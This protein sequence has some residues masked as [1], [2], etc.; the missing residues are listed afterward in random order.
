MIQNLDRDALAYKAPAPFE[1]GS[2]ETT[3]DGVVKLP[4]VAY[5]LQNLALC[6]LSLG[7]GARAL[8]PSPPGKQLSLLYLE[9]LKF[10]QSL[11]P[12]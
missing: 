5:D 11:S 1:W 10:I 6:G 12:P 4:T 7:M 8:S 3:V 9:K 2:K